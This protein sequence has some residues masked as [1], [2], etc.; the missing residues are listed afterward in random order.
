MVVVVLVEDLEEEGWCLPK[1]DLMDWK[2]PD[3]SMETRMLAP[4]AISTPR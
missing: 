1:A 3:R 4:I 2:R